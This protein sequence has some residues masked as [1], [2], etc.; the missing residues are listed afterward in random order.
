MLHVPRVYKG[1]HREWS[2]NGY[3][4]KIFHFKGKWEK[5]KNT[6]DKCYRIRLTAAL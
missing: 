6:Y 2:E 1:I 4:D 3:G 5:D